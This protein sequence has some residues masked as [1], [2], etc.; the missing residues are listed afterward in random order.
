MRPKGNTI[1]DSVLKRMQLTG[2][3]NLRQFAKLPRKLWED[4]PHNIQA[5]ADLFTVCYYVPSNI[6]K[7][8]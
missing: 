6:A 8:H 4:N 2:L 7:G 1:K 5:L 3:F